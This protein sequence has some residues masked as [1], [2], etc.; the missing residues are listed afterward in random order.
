[1][2]SNLLVCKAVCQKIFTKVL[3]ELLV[4]GQRASPV[5]VQCRT[6]RRSPGLSLS[7]WLWPLWALLPH[8]GM[9]EPNTSRCLAPVSFCSPDCLRGEIRKP[10]P[11][12]GAGYHLLS[13]VF[14][15]FKVWTPLPAPVMIFVSCW[16]VNWNIQLASAALASE[17]ARSQTGSKNELSC[18]SSSWCSEC[19]YFCYCGYLFKHCWEEKSVVMEVTTHHTAFKAVV[20]HWKQICALRC[21]NT[22]HKPK[23]W[24]SA[25]THPHVAASSLLTKE[26]CPVLA[27]S[28]RGLL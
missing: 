16:E 10:W 8:A 20:P 4:G 22:T 17:T 6:M 3:L 11:H 1:M 21:L 24:A 9:L 28:Q 14:S 26:V 2:C 23:G 12:F 15:L 27:H 5:L 25:Q 19:N 7:V 18:S 13:A